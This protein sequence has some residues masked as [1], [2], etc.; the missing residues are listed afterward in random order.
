MVVVVVMKVHIE[1]GECDMERTRRREGGT[2]GRKNEKEGKGRIKD[3][4]SACVV[5]CYHTCLA[6]I[7]P[8]IHPSSELH[9]LHKHTPPN[10]SIRESQTQDQAQLHT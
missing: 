3:K 9:R 6:C 5:N 8:K 7:D 2:G 4:W 1:C 10:P